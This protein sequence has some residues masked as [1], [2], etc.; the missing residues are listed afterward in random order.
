VGLARLGRV[1]SRQVAVDSVAWF[2]HAM[3]LAWIVLFAV[4]IF[5]Q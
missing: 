1:E 3:N 4:L 5:G 2:W